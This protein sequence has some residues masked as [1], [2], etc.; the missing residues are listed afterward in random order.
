MKKEASYVSPEMEVYEI[1]AEGVFCTS[2]DLD[3][4]SEGGNM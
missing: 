3:M 1:I 2:D 4:D